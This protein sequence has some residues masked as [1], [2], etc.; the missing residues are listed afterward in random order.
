MRLY[1]PFSVVHVAVYL[2]L[3]SVFLTSSCF[4]A[5][6]TKSNLYFLGFPYFLPVS[7]IIK[8]YL[9]LSFPIPVPHPICPSVLSFVD[10]FDSTVIL[11]CCVQTEL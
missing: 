2:H 8:V 9:P 11:L 4:K 3:L 1:F 10:S 6:Y 7:V 5:F